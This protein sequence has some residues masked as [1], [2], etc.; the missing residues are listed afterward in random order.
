M[1]KMLKL[2]FEYLQDEKKASS[3]TLQ[4]YKRDLKQFRQYLEYKDAHYNKID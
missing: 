1:E 2:F 3:N 4:S